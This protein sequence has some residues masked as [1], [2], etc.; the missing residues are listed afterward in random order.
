MSGDRTVRS[1]QVVTLSSEQREFGHFMDALAQTLSGK[2]Q[3]ER[4]TPAVPPNARSRMAQP[5]RKV[6]ITVDDDLSL[7]DLSKAVSEA[8]QRTG[9]DGAGR[10]GSKLKLETE[11]ATWPEA[12]QAIDQITK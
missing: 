4:E 11:S 6:H 5:T 3:I 1:K 8:Y 2:V 7:D 12:K 9:V 10:G